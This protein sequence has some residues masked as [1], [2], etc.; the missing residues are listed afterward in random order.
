[1]TEAK[2]RE[3]N[4]PAKPRAARGQGGAHPDQVAAAADVGEALGRALGVE[5][6]VRPTP[7]GG[8]RAELT[9]DDAEQAHE[10]AARLSAERG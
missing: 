5:V 2:A 10:L 8:Y 1:V 3:A 4:A 9:F 6:R 7:A